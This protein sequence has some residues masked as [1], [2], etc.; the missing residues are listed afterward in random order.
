VIRF[1]GDPAT[2]HENYDFVHCTNYWTSETRRIITNTQA[3]ECILG[4]ELKY[5]GS[6]YPVASLFRTRKFIKRGWHITAGQ[7]FKIANQ[8]SK[9]D[10]NNF[11]ILQDQLTGVDMAYFEELINKLKSKNSDTVDSSYLIQLIDEIF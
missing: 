8:V 4:R 10:L 3:L 1:Y 6:K 5:V 7:M 9:L 2:I 11:T